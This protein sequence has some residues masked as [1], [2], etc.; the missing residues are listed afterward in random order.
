MRVHIESDEDKV[1]A[2][3]K[4]NAFCDTLKKGQF[5]NLSMNPLLDRT[6]ISKEQVPGGVVT[7]R[8]QFYTF[9]VLVFYDEHIEPERPKGNYIPS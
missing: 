9:T 5:Q 1:A 2:I 7:T 4:A 3:A 8:K 6:E